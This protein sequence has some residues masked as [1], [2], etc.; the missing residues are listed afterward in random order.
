MGLE[1]K[2]DQLLGRVT[3]I[4]TRLSVWQNMVIPMLTGF[5][6]VVSGI[7]LAIFALKG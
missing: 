6:G 7:L 2:I 4:E 3:V 1:E 5:V